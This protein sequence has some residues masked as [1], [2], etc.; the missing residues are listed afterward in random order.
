LFQGQYRIFA[1]SRCDTCQSGLDIVDAQINIS[2]NHQI[3]EVPDL[4]IKK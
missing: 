2:S 1:Y 4:I 3:I